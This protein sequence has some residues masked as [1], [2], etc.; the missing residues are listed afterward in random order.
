MP[1]PPLSGQWIRP[2]LTLAACALALAVGAPMAAAENSRFSSG[3]ETVRPGGGDREP[4]RLEI[5]GGSVGRVRFEVGPLV[6]PLA[7]ATLSLYVRRGGLGLEVRG[8]ADDQ[9]IT[10]LGGWLKAG[11]RYDFDVTS[12]IRREGG[13]HVF[14]LS[15]RSKRRLVLAAG[16][17][18]STYL[19]PRLRMWFE[20][21][22]WEPRPEPGQDA[23]GDGRSA[24]ARDALLEALGSVPESD[25]FRYD[26]K[27]DRGYGLDTLKIIQ[28]GKGRYLGVYHALVG[29]R[30]TV[31]VATSRNLLE[32]RHR[33]FLAG[34]ASQPTIARIGRRGF[35]VAYEQSGPT[36]SGL[37]FR[38]YPDL[39]SIVTAR[40]TREFNAPQTL[41]RAAQGTPNIYGASIENG[42]GRSHIRV[43]LHYF[44]DGV[45]D[46]QATGTLRDFSLWH[47][48]RQPFLDNRPRALGARGHVGDRDHIAFE[49][50][51]FNVHEAE[52]VPGD[53]SS[54][55]T[56]L[57]DFRSR[58]AY[59]LHPKTHG[60]SFAFGNPTVTE[61][62]LPNGK[63]G[64]VITQ[65]LFYEG[66]APGESG[67]L[68]YYR[69]LE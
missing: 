10:S 19:H 4:G 46:R 2:A 13:R 62:T 24:P 31:M 25:G 55:R 12:A 52:I 8:A 54:W 53:W 64:L 66:A 9:L 68:V 14:T 28:I 63:R 67:Q 7:R 49:G 50:Y 6:S 45:V 18:V 41:S 42:I 61:L 5:G 40:Y 30:F 34:N 27:D 39:K 38:Y 44:R 29:G 47:A 22:P 36:G 35:L 32:W 69:E 65:F 59:W 21:P 23:A 56:Y 1:P 20:E 17:S 3:T 58:S 15:S 11:R 48:E 43:G 60:G 16:H 26:A 51:D 33:T 57:Y 37:R